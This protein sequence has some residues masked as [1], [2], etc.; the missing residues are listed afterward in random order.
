[1]GLELTTGRYPQITSQTLLQSVKI[2]RRF[3][4]CTICHLRVFTCTKTHHSIVENINNLFDEFGY[5]FTTCYI[6][7]V[8][9]FNSYN[10]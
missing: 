1:M 10:S 5:H 4:D 7:T 9:L 8:D 6:T 2:S 3:F